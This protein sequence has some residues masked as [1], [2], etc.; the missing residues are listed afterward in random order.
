MIGLVIDK[1]SENGN[2]RNT[3]KTGNPESFQN[4]LKMSAEALQLILELLVTNESVLGTGQRRALW[5]EIL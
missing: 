5:A 4:S 2:V 3:S 1:V